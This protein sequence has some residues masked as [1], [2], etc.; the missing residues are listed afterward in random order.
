MIPMNTPNQELITAD[1]QRGDSVGDGERACTDREEHFAREWVRTGNKA[2]AYRLAYNVA[3]TTLPGTVW[4]EAS[5]VANRPRVQARYNE[6]QQQASLEMIVTV[7][8]VLKWHLDVATAD[9]NEIA[10]NAQRACRYCYGDGHRW[11]WVD[12]YE[13]ADACAKAM[14][15][16]K[17]Y[18]PSDDGGYGYTKFKSPHPECPKCNGHGFSETVTNDTR[19]LSDK[20]RKLYRGIDIKNGEHVVMLHDQQKAWDNVC[21]ILGAFNDKLDIGLLLGKR[22]DAGRIAEGVSEQ[23]A[24]RQYLE[25]LG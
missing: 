20:A 21:R 25:F 11:Q 13:Y 6:L 4:T 16:R 14:D 19:F 1:E 2:A 23:E 18:M 9:P 22:A 15:E 3:P 8:E 10:Y 12:D 5:R 24:A 17:P 7:Q